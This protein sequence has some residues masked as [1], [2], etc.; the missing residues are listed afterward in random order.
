MNDQDERTH[1]VPIFSEFS[2][3]RLVAIYDTVNPIAEYETF[4]LDLAARL[5]ASSIIDVGCGTGLLTCELAK[6]GHRLTG[7]E[8]SGEML[9]LA[10]RRRCGDQVEIGRASCRERV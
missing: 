1:D 4:Y 9:T 6:R 8:P 10:R 7:V 5:S 2:D 3:P